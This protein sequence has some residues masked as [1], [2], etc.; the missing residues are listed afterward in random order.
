MFNFFNDLSIRYKLIS[1]FSLFAVL[2]GIFV[3]IFFP[4]QQKKQILERVIE[5]SMTITDVADKFRR[6]CEYSINPITKENQDRVIEIIES[7][8][9]EQDTGNIVSLLA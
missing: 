3:F 7:L 6:C 4:H 5:N 9:E 1:T 8:E 2:V